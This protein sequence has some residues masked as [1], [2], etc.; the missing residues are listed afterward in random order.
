MDRELIDRLGGPAKVAELLGF[1]KTKGGV[2]RVHNWKERGIPPA[3]KL[4]HPD[5]FL[6]P[7]KSEVPAAQA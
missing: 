4:A 2:Q 7:P 1:D 3:I 5:I 6:N